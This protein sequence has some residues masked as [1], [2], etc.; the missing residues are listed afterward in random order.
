MIRTPFVPRSVF[1]AERSLSRRRFLGAAVGTLGALGAGL[2][3]PTRARAA[4]RDPN[5]M[6]GGVGANP[7]GGPLI[8]ANFPGPADTPGPG[9][10]PG[11]GG[12]GGNDPSSITDF[13][14]YIGVAAVDGTGTGTNTN[15]GDTFPLLFDCDLRFMK[16]VYRSV[17]GRF[18]D[19]RFVFGCLDLYQGQYDF[20]GFTTNVYDFHSVFSTPSG[21]LWTTPLPRDNPLLINFDDGEATLIADLDLLDYG[22][23]PNALALGAGVPAD[24]T[25][26]VR[27]SG[28]ISRMVSVQDA[29]HGF[30]GQF[31]E[32]AATLSWTA[33]R[34]GFMFASDPASTST[35][36][37]AQLGQESNGIFF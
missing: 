23:F 3:L 16:G 20:T 29:A 4:G 8:H 32:N 37:F 6:P 19:A 1:R 26:E 36:S 13:E 11:P 2:L 18:L 15:T 17:D 35:S 30:R 34:A 12:G 33:S 25:F 14:G 24:V 28:P 31:L 21:V 5:P 27:W 7:T 9:T 10:H 22:N